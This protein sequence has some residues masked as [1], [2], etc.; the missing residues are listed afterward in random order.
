MF[1]HTHLPVHPHKRYCHFTIKE[2]KVQSVFQTHRAN[3]QLVQ[4][5]KSMLFALFISY[6]CPLPIAI[7]P[8]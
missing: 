6:C 1:H 7:F 8:E 4:S 2:T 3:E 5:L